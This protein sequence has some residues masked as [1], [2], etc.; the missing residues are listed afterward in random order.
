MYMNK[1]LTDSEI[2]IDVDSEDGDI[3]DE[4]GF[5][6]V[7]VNSSGTLGTPN[8]EG[9]ELDIKEARQVSKQLVAFVARVDKRMITAKARSKKI[10]EKNRVA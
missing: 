7:R 8:T 2:Y 10:V 1:L 3:Y 9:I 4:I 5:M 6:I